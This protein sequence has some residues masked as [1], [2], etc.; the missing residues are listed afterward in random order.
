VAGDMTS[1]D[2]VCP[3]F[4]GAK[5]LP[6]LLDSVR[7][8]THPEFR[9]WIRDDGSS[10]ETVEMIEAA[11]ATDHRLVRVAGGERLGVAGS[12]ARLVAQ[13]PPDSAY[14]MCAD[15][16][17]V[18]F[19]DKIERT[20]AAMLAAE[21]AARPAHPILVHS[22]L[23]VVDSELKVLDPSYWAYAR[24][25]PEP[26]SLRRLVVRNVVTGAT[27][28]INRRLRELIGAM[29]AD[30]IHHDWWFACV[31][32]AFG[33]I[34]ALPEATMFYRQHG[35]NS[36]GARDR[37][38][39]VRRLPHVVVA[40]LTSGSAFKREIRQSSA[41]GRA[42]LERY[43]AALAPNDRDFLAA[44]SLIPDQRFLPRKLAVAR[45]RALPEFGVWRNLGA[46]LRG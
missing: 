15:Q 25:E 9:L 33:T 38:I 20:L 27:M 39:G 11:V 17:D 45:L 21:S 10:D 26:V 2:I 7:R 8:Q 32:A 6:E 18:W 34:V 13:L 24:L 28:M 3:T 19:D 4:N 35:S 41:Q 16:D 29:P 1:V 23:V 22:D 31:A 36:V 14:I 5:F 40:G 30:A 37:R 44:Y 43:G 46:V 12:F 42:F